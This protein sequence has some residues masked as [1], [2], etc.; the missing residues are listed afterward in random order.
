[1]TH[2][3]DPCP[4]CGA[5]TEGGLCPDC[6]LCPADAAYQEALDAQEAAADR[7]GLTDFEAGWSG[8]NY[9]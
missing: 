3:S 5:P 6:G 4:R 8:R 7:E 1:M 2:F 9:R